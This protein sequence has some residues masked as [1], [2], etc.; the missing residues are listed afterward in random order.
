MEKITL[1]RGLKTIINV[2]IIVAIITLLFWI[3]ILFKIYIF[4]DA[5]LVMKNSAKAS[6]FGYLIADLILA[7]PILVASISSLSKLKFSGW[8]LAQFANILWIYSLLSVWIR[9]LYAKEITPGDIIFLPLIPFSIWS[10]QY[11][12]KNRNKFIF[13]TDN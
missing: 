12:W 9:D 7:V 10:I 13:T 11:L 5:N 4:P 6:T 2:N 1:S 3:L 8:L